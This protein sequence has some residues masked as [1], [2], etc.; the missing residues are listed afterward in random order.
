MADAIFKRRTKMEKNEWFTGAER[1][2]FLDPKLIEFVQVDDEVYSVGEAI[3]ALKKAGLAN[4]NRT[5]R[6]TT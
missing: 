1:R 4:R 5:R 3:E 2:V 6:A